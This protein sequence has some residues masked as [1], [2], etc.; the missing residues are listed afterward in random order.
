M[1]TFHQFII[2]EATPPAPT[3]R[4]KPAVP[5]ST[6]TPPPSGGGGIPGFGSGPPLGMGG[7]PMGL[8]GPPIGGPSLSGGPGP[9]MGDS[10]SPSP[11][12][13]TIQKIK[14]SNV[15]DALRKSLK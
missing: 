13:V 2:S 14:S 1:I 7:P 11:S 15:W 8:G 5:S 6:S 12:G 3:P 4:G 10:S 9:A